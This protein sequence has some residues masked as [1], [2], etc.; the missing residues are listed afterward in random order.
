MLN[1]A[2]NMQFHSLKRER[3]LFGEKHEA[4][5]ANWRELFLKG[6]YL[7]NTPLQQGVGRARNKRSRFNGFVLAS[8]Q[9]ATSIRTHARETV[10]TVRRGLP[11]QDSPTPLKRG[12]N[13]T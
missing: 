6:L 13:E 3:E 10:E 5:S 9:P 11:I 4:W 8:F 2:V 7:I 12:V 1:I